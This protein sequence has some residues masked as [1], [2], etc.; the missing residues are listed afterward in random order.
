MNRWWKVHQICVECG[1][2]LAQ[3]AQESQCP[4]VIACCHTPNV[5]NNVATELLIVA[6]ALSPMRVLMAQRKTACTTSLFLI[7]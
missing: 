5:L 1:V 4:T 6:V 7:M 3:H 2:R